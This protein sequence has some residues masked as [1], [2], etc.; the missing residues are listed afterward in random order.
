M[1]NEGGAL[2]NNARE[3]F[4]TTSSLF[5]AM[6]DAATRTQIDMEVSA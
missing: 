4:P 2:Y 6:R 3:M 5:N 1:R